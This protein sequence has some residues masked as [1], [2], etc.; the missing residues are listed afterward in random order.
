MTCSA[1]KFTYLLLLKLSVTIVTVCVYIVKWLN[2]TGS[3]VISG[4]C[5]CHMCLQMVLVDSPN[6]ISN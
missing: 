2:L 3:D 5:S 1:E 4:T 6:M